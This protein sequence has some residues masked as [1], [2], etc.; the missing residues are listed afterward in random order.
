MQLWHRDGQTQA[1]LGRALQLDPSTVTRMVTRLEKQGIVSRAASPSDRRAV[2]ISLMPPSEVL[3]PE[4]RRVWAEL[5]E[6]TIAGIPLQLR[7]HLMEGLALVSA[8]LGG[9][10]SGAEFGGPPPH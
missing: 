2:I 1:E 8:A 3:Q 10:G 9:A 4:V 5:E 6:V 7:H